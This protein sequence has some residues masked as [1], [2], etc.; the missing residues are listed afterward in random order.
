MFKQLTRLFGGGIIGRIIALVIVCIAVAVIIAM[1]A[2]IIIYP[3]FFLGLLIGT[4]FSAEAYR[5]IY[6][7]AK[8]RSKMSVSEDTKEIFTLTMHDFIDALGWRSR[9]V[10][11]LREEC[12]A[13]EKSATEA[14]LRIERGTQSLKDTWQSLVD[15]NTIK[16]NI[17]A[18]RKLM[19]TRIKKAAMLTFKDPSFAKLSEELEE[20][21]IKFEN[22]LA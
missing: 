8:K 22:F 16:E 4:A 19:S 11:A 2:A 1:A 17:L 5:R 7:I 20:E 13:K 12:R 10:D 18:P 15:K 9:D 14:V 3:L 6:A 21:T